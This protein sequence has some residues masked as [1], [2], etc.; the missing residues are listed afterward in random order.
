MS[1]DSIRGDDGRF[2]LGNPGGPGRPRSTVSRGAVELDEIGADAG[3]QLLQ[4]MMDK[5]LEGDTRAG[6]LLL[7][8]IWPSRRGRPVEIESTP[9]KAPDDYVAAAAD[10]TNAVMRGEMTPHEG[11]AVSS[12]LELQVKAIDMARITRQIEE[13]KERVA[14]IKRDEKKGGERGWGIYQPY[15]TDRSTVSDRLPNGSED[16]KA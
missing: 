6:E 1:D 3:K 8:R 10:V 12:L 11:R 4:V 7:A 16:E 14:E 5:A 13:L 15:P 2:I 9:I